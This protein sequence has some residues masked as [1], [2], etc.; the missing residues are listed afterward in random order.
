MCGLSAADPR[1]RLLISV[2]TTVYDQGCWHAVIANVR[3]RPT[4]MSLSGDYTEPISNDCAARLYCR[5]NGSV[6]SF[7]N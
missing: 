6:T 1:S 7:S 5:A 4:H 3:N 2:R